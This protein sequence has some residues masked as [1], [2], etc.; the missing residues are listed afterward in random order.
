MH[1]RALFVITLIF[2]FFLSQFSCN[3]M[4]ESVS[5]VSDLDNSEGKITIVTQDDSDGSVEIPVGGILQIELMG[6]GSTGHW[7]YFDVLDDEYITI[8]DEY[9]KEI[10]QEKI[11]GGPVMGVWKLM[12]QKTGTTH[13]EMVYRRSWEKDVAPSGRF[14]ITVEIDASNNP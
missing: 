13:V 8:I 9:T 3:G 11:E 12:T 1:H 6:T 2:I 7:W 5:E 10:T 4:N 14:T